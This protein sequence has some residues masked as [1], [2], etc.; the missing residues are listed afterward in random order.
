M[1]I[2]QFTIGWE[3]REKLT[4]LP[5]EDKNVLREAYGKVIEDSYPRLAG[6]PRVALRYFDKVE[7]TRVIHV[8]SEK[9][10]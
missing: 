1:L 3:N 9:E 8:S 10:Q 4:N 7:V 6:D 2:C 5:E